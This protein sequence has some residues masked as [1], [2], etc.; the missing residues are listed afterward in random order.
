MLILY[1]GLFSHRELFTKIKERRTISQFYDRLFDI[2]EPSLWHNKK[3]KDLHILQPTSTKQ[4]DVWKRIFVTLRH[5]RET[6]ETTIKN[7]NARAVS[8]LSWAI[9]LNTASSKWKR[10]RDKNLQ[11]LSLSPYVSQR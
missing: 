9:N 3:S 10:K 6:F 8:L 1:K 7:K 4:K 5:L 2:I 11:P